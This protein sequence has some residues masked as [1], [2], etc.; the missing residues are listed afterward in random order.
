MEDTKEKKIEA[1]IEAD[2]AYNALLE[3]RAKES[4][5]IMAKYVLGYP[6]IGSIHEE[7]EVWHKKS[8][9]KFKLLLVPR[10]HLKSTFWTISYALRRIAQDNNIRILIANATFGNAKNFTSTIRRHIEGNQTF[11]NLYGSLDRDKEGKRISDD[12]SQVSFTIKRTKNMPEPTVYAAGVGGNVVSQHYD[13]ILWDDLVND[14]NVTTMEMIQQMITWWQNSLSLLESDGEGIMIGTRWDFND[15]YSHVMEHF[16]DDFDIFVHSCYNKD[17]SVYFPEKFSYEELNRLKKL[18]RT[19]IF[20]CQYLNDPTDD[21]N[22]PFAR[23]YR[24]W[25]KGEPEHGNIY[26]TCDPSTGLGKDYS[27][28]IVNAVTQHNDWFILDEIKKKLKI[29]ELIEILWNLRNRYRKNF[30]RM[31]IEKDLYHSMIEKGLRELMRIHN[32]FFSVEEVPAPRDKSKQAK[33]MALQPRYEAGTIFFHPKRHDLEYEM[34]RFPNMASESYDLLDALWMQNEIA[35]PAEIKN[36]KKTPRN[37][38]KG[39][40]DRYKKAKAHP[41]IIGSDSG[42]FYERFMNN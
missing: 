40:V 11:R 10:G 21:E 34:D 25:W 3:R 41:H 6:D 12:W 8:K 2:K 18:Q 23:K 42:S 13:L 28:I 9:K 30:K 20:S 15:L 24:K 22:S 16:S 4:T 5:V 38:F 39:I 7:W 35:K 29:E 1:L 19:Y 36:V 33:I 32:D 17:G 14:K 37:S 27:G 31:A 26:I